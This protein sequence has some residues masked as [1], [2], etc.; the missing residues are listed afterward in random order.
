FNG[1]CTVVLA[2]FHLLRPQLSVFG[3]KDAQQ[4][5]V[6]RAMVR[7]LVVPV[8]IVGAPIVREP[9]GVAM[10]SRNR[11]LSPEERVR[12]RVLSRALA[13]GAAAGIEGPSAVLHAARAVLAEEPEVDV[14]YLDL[15]TPDFDAATGGGAA[16]NGDAL[17]VVAA[18]VGATRLLDNRGVA[19][20]AAPAAE[21]TR[22]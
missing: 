18:R 7:D 14:D 15:V 1:V 16:I 4:L 17:L 20:P 19:L 22:P 5:A 9:D 8:E 13:A 21:G 11:Y 12:A 10:S 2:L 3:E 6:I